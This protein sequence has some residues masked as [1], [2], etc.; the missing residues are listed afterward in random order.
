[1]QEKSLYLLIT[2]ACWLT[3]LSPAE[4]VHSV[5]NTQP[6]I[7]MS[8]QAEE[9]TPS[10]HPAGPQKKKEKKMDTLSLVAHISI[11]AGIASFF[12]LPQ[13]SLLLIPAAFIMGLL[14]VTGRKDRLK[15]K[16]GRG[17]AI[18]ALAV[19]GFFTLVVFASFAIY[20]LSF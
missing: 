7:S 15:S 12:F 1:M 6:S 5:K 18:A 19:G 16:R 17:L 9:K 2:L 4:A 13:L 14:A 10:D 11:M 3:F 20:A 8:Q